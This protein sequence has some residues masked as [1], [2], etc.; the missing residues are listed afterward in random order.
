MG[1]RTIEVSIQFWQQMCTKGFKSGSFECVKGLPEGAEYVG[2]FTDAQG[3]IKLVFD[4]PDWDEVVL[5]LV[6]NVPEIPVE[7]RSC[8]NDDRHFRYEDRG[9]IR[10]ISIV[11]GVITTDWPSH[12]TASWRFVE[13]L[14]HEVEELT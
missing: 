2:G 10:H 5:R 7:F 3:V 6:G 8:P 13:P 9:I 1:R 12:G 11:D 4:H 14:E